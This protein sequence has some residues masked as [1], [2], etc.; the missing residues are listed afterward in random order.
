MR[1]F[2]LQGEGKVVIGIIY[3]DVLELRLIPQPL[4]G[5]RNIDFQHDIAWPRIHRHVP[6]LPDR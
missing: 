6:T 2:H 3:R 5:K 1:A 4:E